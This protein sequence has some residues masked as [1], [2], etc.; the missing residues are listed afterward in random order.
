MTTLDAARQVLE[1][2]QWLAPDASKIAP[3]L[4]GLGKLVHRPTGTWVHAEGDEDTG[5]LVVVDGAVDLFC[6]GVGERRVRV[7]LVGPGA[8]VGQSARFGGTRTFRAAHF[9]PSCLSNSP[10]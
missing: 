10:W 1:G 9:L 8:T 5:L 4:V 3:L 6:H 7:G 2:A